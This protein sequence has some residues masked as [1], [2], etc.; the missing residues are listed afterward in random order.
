MAIKTD[1]QKVKTI[2]RVSDDKDLIADTQKL[3]EYIKSH[4]S[5][6]TS[7]YNALYNAYSCNAAILSA[8]KKALNKPDHRVAVNFPRYVVD[9]YSGF[10]RGI[11][12]TI[13]SDDKTVDDYI[14]N[15]IDRT[16]LDDVNAE[17]H[18]N[19]CIFGESYQIVFVDEEG[20]IGTVAVDPLEAFPIYSNSIRPKLRYFVRTFY[21][22][23]NK[24]HGT[25]SD[26][27]NVYEFDFEGGEI[28]ITESHPHG[29]P[30]VPAVVYTMNTSR[31]GLIEIILPMADAYDRAIS[32]KANDVDS[33]ADAILKVLGA[34]L[35]EEQLDNLRD[36]RIINIGGKD[37]AGVVVDFLGK[38]SGDSTQENLLERLE[39]LIFTISMVCNVSDNNFATSSGIAL[40]MK[41]EPMSN[42]AAGDWR[43][44][45]SSMKNFWKLVFGNPVNTVSPDA[46]ESITLSNSLNYPDDLADAAATARTLDG[47]VSKRTQLA[48]LP[49]S[50]VPD[51]D[52][53]LER[54]AEEQQAAQEAM[55]AA[56][57]AMKATQETEDEAEAEADTESEADEEI[58]K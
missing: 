30:G 49:G 52:A 55:I 48:S 12:V 38:P 32:E 35:S 44:D 40:K 11:P 27:I 21:D 58:A 16:D 6:V 33:F 53:E 22:E 13:S 7:K 14:Q 17:I 5:I 37:G 39:R 4:D 56:Q 19:K 18:K 23:D 41:M 3:N 9:T 45:K 46:W 31:I 43:S 26:D 29:F 25:I 15:V 57:E 47:I 51:V 8:A 54:I 50:L 36:R 42:M 28:N 34:N 1:K 24:R 2:L 10:A 20:E